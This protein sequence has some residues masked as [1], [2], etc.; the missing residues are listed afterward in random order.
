MSMN[1]I[2]TWWKGLSKIRRRVLKGGAGVALGATAGFAYYTFVGCSTGACPI[3][4]D[5]MIS[6]A[7]GAVIGG[8]W[9]VG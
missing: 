5:P 7:W 4:S 9:A 8:F 6:T 2:K 3:T 1:S